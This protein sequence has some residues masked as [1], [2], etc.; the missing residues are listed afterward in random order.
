M[1]SCASKT[2]EYMTK[3]KPLHSPVSGSMI[4]L[5][6]SI[7]PNRPASKAKPASV[8]DLGK[9]VTYTLRTGSSGGGVG[10]LRWCSNCPFLR[11][12]GA[13]SEKVPRGA[14]SGSSQSAHCILAISVPQSA[15]G[16]FFI[17]AGSVMSCHCELGDQGDTSGCAAND[18]ERDAEA[19]SAL[20]QSKPA[21]LLLMETEGRIAA[22][23]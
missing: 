23:D 8:I 5:C 11:G 14:T 22:C 4:A 15:A 13:L 16:L 20:P 6:D 9:S 21:W 1:A 18:L 7:I 17:G 2:V 3:P 10:G 19:A 12:G